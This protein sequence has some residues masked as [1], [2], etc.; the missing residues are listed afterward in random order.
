MA[1]LMPST[2]W[3]SRATHGSAPG[4]RFSVLFVQKRLTA[5]SAVAAFVG[6]E[7]VFGF[8][9]PPKVRRVLKAVAKP[10]FCG[11]ARLVVRETQFDGCTFEPHIEKFGMNGCADLTE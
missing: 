7:S 1:V 2:D 4:G 6:R 9:E 8:E 10:D 3:E 5:L 11:R